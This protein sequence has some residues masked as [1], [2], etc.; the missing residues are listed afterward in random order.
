MPRLPPWPPPLSAT[1]SV[2]GASAQSNPHK[3]LYL[4]ATNQNPEQDLPRSPTSHVSS[5]RP[6]HLLHAQCVSLL[7]WDAVQSGANQSRKGPLELQ[8]G[9]YKEEI[10]LRSRASFSQTTSQISPSLGVLRPRNSQEKQ[11]AHLLHTQCVSCFNR[12]FAQSEMTQALET[13][14]GLQKARA[15]RC[16]ISHHRRAS[17]SQTTSSASP[18]VAFAPQSHTSHEKQSAHLLHTQCVSCS[19]RDSETLEMKQA[20]EISL[21]LRKARV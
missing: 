19:E 18:S 21:A 15:S 10:V 17:S 2:K 6:A 11:P 14:L 8:R 1:P 20:R 7:K 12:D 3:S 13:S 4:F 5:K 9:A 16:G